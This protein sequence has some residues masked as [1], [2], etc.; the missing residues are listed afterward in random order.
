MAVDHQH[1]VTAAEMERLSPDERA[2]LLN[3]RVI[4]DLSQV[5]PAF[6]SR[7]LVKGRRLVD[8]HRNRA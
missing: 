1:V 3:D 2:R 5:S 8:E 6:L 4:T 7:V